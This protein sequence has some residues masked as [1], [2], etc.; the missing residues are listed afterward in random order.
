MLGDIVTFSYERHARREVPVDAKVVR[1]R[2]DVVWEDIVRDHV[3]SNNGKINNKKK[4]RIK[5]KEKKRK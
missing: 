1:V 4:K 3:S 2:N 5:K